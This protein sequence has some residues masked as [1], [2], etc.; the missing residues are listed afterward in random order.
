MRGGLRAAGE[1]QHVLP[2]RDQLDGRAGQQ[3]S[4]PGGVG[5]GAC[6]GGLGEA[7]GEYKWRH[8]VVLNSQILN[9]ARQV[10]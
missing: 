2:D 6:Q 7:C 9:F 10:S 8:R 1:I 5:G 3:A 4:Q